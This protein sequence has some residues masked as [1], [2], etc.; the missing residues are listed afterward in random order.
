MENN[1]KHILPTFMDCNF[2]LPDQGIFE[3]AV[4]A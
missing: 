3:N 1:S 2:N 4:L